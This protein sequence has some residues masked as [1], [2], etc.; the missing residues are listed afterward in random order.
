MK[1]AKDDQR[2]KEWVG[3]VVLVPDGIRPQAPT[4]AH[5]RRQGSS[6]AALHSEMPW[7]ARF[8]TMQFVKGL[9]H[10]RGCW[11]PLFP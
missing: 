1:V 10:E 4:A 7:G 11:H 6:F 9:C 5:R 8:S 2:V 3:Q